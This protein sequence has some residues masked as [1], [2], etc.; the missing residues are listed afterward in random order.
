LWSNWWNEDWQGKPKYTEKLPQ[1]HFIPHDPGSN[2]DRRGGKP[3]TNRLSYG[4]AYYGNGYFFF[5]TNDIKANFSFVTPTTRHFFHYE[6]D[7]DYFLF[8]AEAT[9]Q[10]YSRMPPGGV[11]G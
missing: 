1:R 11:P 4:A 5:F 9:R 2:P 7:R 6:C 3:L 10:F 8:M